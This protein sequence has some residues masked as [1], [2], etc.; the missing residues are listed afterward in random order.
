LFPPSS[1]VHSFCTNPSSNG[2]RVKLDKQCFGAC[3]ARHTFSSPISPVSSFRRTHHR[4]HNGST[5]LPSHCTA[6]LRNRVQEDDSAQGQGMQPTEEWRQGGQG[7]QG[8]RNGKTSRQNGTSN[9][10]NSRGAGEGADQSRTMHVLS[11]S[12]NMDAQASSSS[13]SSSRSAL[14]VQPPITSMATL[15]HISPAYSTCLTYAQASPTPI[16]QL[17]PSAAHAAHPGVEKSGRLPAT[18]SSIQGSQ[19]SGEN[20]RSHSWQH[21]AWTFD[22]PHEAAD[23]EAIKR[24]EQARLD[25]HAAKAAA[26]PA[27]PT[28]VTR[29]PAHLTPQV[30]TNAVLLVD[31]PQDWSTDEVARALTWALKSSQ[32][33]YV[34]ALEPMA[35]GLMVVLIGKA[36]SLT[37]E[38]QSVPQ[39]YTGVLQLGIETDTHDTCGRVTATMPWSHVTDDQIE[40]VASCFRGEFIQVPPAYNPVKQ[41]SRPVYD[42]AQRRPQENLQPMAVRTTELSLRRMEPGSSELAFSVT[43]SRTLHV[44]ALARDIGLALGCYAHVSSLRREALGGFCVDDAWPLNVLL[45]TARKF[46]A[47]VRRGLPGRKLG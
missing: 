6:Y 15:A 31:K 3:A 34:G 42:L 46:K 27:R 37:P 43:Y 23:V 32:L 30:L 45:P 13:S 16:S 36:T 33:G 20:V 9:G 44:R 18:G 40:E 14:A 26:K 21:R 7:R 11:C 19:G 17:Q 8:S 1:S 28:L 10:S 12:E 38:L 35:S 2:Q 29:L 22:A 5:R 39:R 41:K 47:L 24:L 4:P 25:R